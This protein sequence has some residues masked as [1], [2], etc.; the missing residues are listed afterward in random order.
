MAAST[1]PTPAAA[2]SPRTIPGAIGWIVVGCLGG[3]LAT[4]A[5]L[6][7]Q[8]VAGA[9]ASRALWLNIVETLQGELQLVEGQPR[10]ASLPLGAIFAAVA[11]VALVSWLAGAGLITLFSGRTFRQA[12]AEWGSRGWKWWCPAG[13]WYLMWLIAVLTAGTALNSLLV[14][15]VELWWSVA[16]AGWLTTLLGLLPPPVQQDLAPRRMPGWGVVAATV[17][18]YTLVFGAMNWQL[19]EGLLIPHGDSAMYEEHLWNITHGKGFRSYLDQGLFLGEHMQVIHLA[20]LP[21]YLLWPSHLLLEVAESLALALTAVPVYTITLRHT[22]SQKAA[23]WLAAATL[24]Y[25]PLQYLDIAIDLKTFRPISF[26]VPLLLLAIDQ[27]ERR[28][29]KTMIALLLVTLTAKEDYAIVIAPLGVWLCLTSWWE[30]RLRR[31]EAGSEGDAGARSAIIIGAAMAVLASIY[32]LLAVKV[33]IPWFREGETVHYARYFSRFG[34]TP[35][36]IVVTML[37][38]PGLLLGEFLTLGTLL[39]ALRVLVPLGGTPL[40]S[41]T[42][43]LVG[44]PLFLLLCLNELAQE[45]PAPVH[46][47][48][49]PLLPIVFWAAAA[50]LP[51]A[52]RCLQWFARG[53]RLIPQ[54]AMLTA[55]RFACLCALTSGVVMSLHPLSRKFWDAGSAMHWRRLYVPGERVERFAEIYPLIPPSARVAST[56][57]VH[58]RFTHHERSYDYSGYLRKVSGYERRVPDDTDYIVIDT[59]HPYSTMHMP[60]DVPEF[61]QTDEWELLTTEPDP[62]FIVLKRRH[63]D[64]NAG[65]DGVDGP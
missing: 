47:F 3:A 14:T 41:P 34:D 59:R 42:R 1:L 10:F 5:V 45:T 13:V 53:R 6:E 57:F 36:E 32:L 55:A 28:R 64:S 54:Q 25:F 4:Q 33:L 30:Q 52:T 39:Y 22:G 9:F 31:R 12:A 8:L 43:L 35:T 27:L 58:P 62:W 7:D 49:A 24:L 63:N 40:L 65:T 60:D 46:H 56:D 21:V 38:Q 2:S 20:L 50:G 17:G 16:A 61:H 29:W 37:T 19:Y 51:N 18:V 48:H 44:A 15:T 11:G 23:G 26:G